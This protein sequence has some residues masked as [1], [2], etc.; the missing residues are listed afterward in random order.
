M[1][2]RAGATLLLVAVLLLAA[3]R[4]EEPPAA[5][6]PE[7]IVALTPSV[8]ETLFALGL[9]ERV[10]GVGSYTTW[11]PA[12]MR[13]PKLGGFFDPNLER[14]VA[15]EPDLAVLTASERDLAA[16]LRP[17]GIATLEVKAETL[18]EVEAS[19]HTIAARCG[20]PAAGEALAARFRAA[21][22]PRP[23]EGSPVVLLSVGRPRGQLAQVTVAG[24]ETFYGELLARL[25]ARNAFP[26][27]PTRYPQVG[28]EEILARHPDVVLELRAQP[29]SP[30]LAAALRAEWA[31]LARLAGRPGPSVEVVSGSHTM[32][33]GPRLPLLYRQM[34]EAL[35][36]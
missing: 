21:L 13:L 27:A 18:A 26:D 25:G 16:K 35:A 1:P 6:A 22:A 12:A 15:L 36:R 11:P 2:R 14:I 10:V 19:F 33:P 24:P 3:C 28:P 20:V 23:V 17:L 34:H 32:L 30:E 29:A 8:V 7:R 4:G 31:E 5:R 9:G